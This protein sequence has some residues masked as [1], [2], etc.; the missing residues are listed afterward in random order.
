MLAQFGYSDSE[1][2]GVDDDNSEEAV[3]VDLQILEESPLAG[4]VNNEEIAGLCSKYKIEVQSWLKLATE[5][6]ETG[7]MRVA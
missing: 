6:M 3:T 1:E 2:E 7:E 5:V 4:M